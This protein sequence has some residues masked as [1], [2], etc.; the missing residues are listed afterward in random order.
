MNRFLIYFLLTFLFFGSKSIAQTIRV[1]SVTLDEYQNA[2]ILKGSLPFD[3]A[4]L[5]VNGKNLKLIKGDTS[6]AVFSL[7]S[8][9]PGSSGPIRIIFLTDTLAGWEINEWYAHVRGLKRIFPPSYISSPAPQPPLSSFEWNLFFRMV[10]GNFGKLITHS[11]I[12]SV[13]STCSWDC[14]QTQP[15]PTLTSE[16]RYIG[17][18]EYQ[19][20]DTSKHSSTGF[21]VFANVN[22]AT[23]S[24]ILEFPPPLGARCKYELWYEGHSP[25]SIL[26]SESSDLSVKLPVL[27]LQI[28]DLNLVLPGHILSDTTIMEW[29]E[30]LDTYW[31]SIRIVPTQIDTSRVLISK[32][33]PRVTFSNLSPN[34]FSTKST[35]YISLTSEEFTTLKIYNPLG[36]E[37]STLVSQRLPAGDHRIEFDASNLPSGIYYYRLQIGGQVE[38]K[39]L[40]VVR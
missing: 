27:H 8:V 38:T 21:I 2:L 18:G 31:D 26:A 24:M 16:A 10:K 29:R 6:E 17:N 40:V 30:L 25:W 12:P 23:D 9:G 13:E 7:P 36:I 20:M 15:W 32:Y 5:T 28:H 39:P 1:D 22:E 37:I 33:T 19:R 35:F 3:F 34:P 14:N 11:A 4:V